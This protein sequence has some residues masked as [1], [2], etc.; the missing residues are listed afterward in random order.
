[1][2]EQNSVLTQIAR[3][4]AA[5]LFDLAQSEGSVDQ[6]EAGLAVNVGMEPFTGRKGVNLPVTRVGRDRVV[7]EI[8]RPRLHRRPGKQCE[9]A[10]QQSPNSKAHKS[11]YFE[12]RVAR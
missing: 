8:G 7:G 12:E 3:P 5:A 10:E 9:A 4:Y 1:M 11:G 2:A 6:V